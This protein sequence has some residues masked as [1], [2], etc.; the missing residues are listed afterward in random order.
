MKVWIF[1]I[2]D[3]VDKA[4][5]RQSDYIAIPN[6][7]LYINSYIIRDIFGQEVT[8]WSVDIHDW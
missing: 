7:K 3:N 1:I 2:R 6:G 5:V 8:A 4:I